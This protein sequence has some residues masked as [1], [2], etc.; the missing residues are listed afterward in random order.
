MLRN[1]TCK[2]VVSQLED[3][4][5]GPG[6]GQLVWQRAGQGVVPY[7][8]EPQAA[9]VGPRSQWQRACMQA[10]VTPSGG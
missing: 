10:S 9:Q 5:A 7:C 2:A 8:E 6:G 3:G 4:E 1:S